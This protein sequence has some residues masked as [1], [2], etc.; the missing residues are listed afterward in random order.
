[1]FMFG[2]EF[3]EDQFP[4]DEQSLREELEEQVREDTPL[5]VDDDDFEDY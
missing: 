3:A 4:P 2:F 1:M 5:D